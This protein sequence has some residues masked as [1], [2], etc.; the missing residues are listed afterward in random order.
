MHCRMIHEKKCPHCGN[1]TNSQER[2]CQLCN[3]L[4]YEQEEKEYV[5]RVENAPQ[6]RLPLIKILPEDAW[7]IIAGKRVVQLGQIIY[8]SLVAFV[9]WVATWAVG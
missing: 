6:M 8:F 3:G 5:R 9:V 2:N 7:Y 4:L 1:W